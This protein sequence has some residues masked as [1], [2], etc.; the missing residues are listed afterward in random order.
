MWRIRQVQCVF[1]LVWALGIVSW[2][3][4]TY[5]YWLVSTSLTTDTNLIAVEKSGSSVSRQE[6]LVVLIC[7]SL[8]TPSMRFSYITFRSVGGTGHGWVASSSEWG[9]LKVS[10]TQKVSVCW[11]LQLDQWFSSHPSVQQICLYFGVSCGSDKTH[12]KCK[13]CIVGFTGHSFKICN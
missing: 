12:K 9:H 1:R 2:G 10:F 4:N 6:V 11:G 8:G 13:I 3:I 7:L 5:Q